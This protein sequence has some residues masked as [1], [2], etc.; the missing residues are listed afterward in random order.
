MQAQFYADGQ[1]HVWRIDQPF[2]AT[3]KAFRRLD[4]LTI[5]ASKPANV[6]GHTGLTYAITVP[7][8][9]IH[10]FGVYIPD[11]NTRATLLDFDD[12]TVMINVQPHG[13]ASR[14]EAR[15]VIQSFSF[16]P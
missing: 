14:A 4:G 9:P 16:P 1:I 3:A 12:A 6:G 8:S 7:G 13:Q 11:G 10:A 15:G 2:A 5:T